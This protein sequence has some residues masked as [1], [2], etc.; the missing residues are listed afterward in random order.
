MKLILVNRYDPK[1][2]NEL[3]LSHY[4]GLEFDVQKVETFQDGTYWCADAGAKPLDFFE[5]AVLSHIMQHKRV[6]SGKGWTAVL[7]RNLVANGKLEEGAYQ[8][9]VSTEP[10]EKE[11]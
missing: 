2:F 1:A 7:L 6:D 11:E 9:V 3:I 8:I 4:D 5:S 10:D